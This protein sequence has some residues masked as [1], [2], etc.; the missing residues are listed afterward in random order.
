MFNWLYY[1]LK[2]ITPVTATQELLDLPY[3]EEGVFPMGAEKSQSAIH[4]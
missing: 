4:V 2:A 3:S 1:C